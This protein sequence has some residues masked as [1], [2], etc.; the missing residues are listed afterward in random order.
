MPFREPFDDAGQQREAAT[1]GMWVF[2]VTELLLFGGLF[3]SYTVLRHFYPDAFRMGSMKTDY[4]KGTINT[5]VLLTSSLT[6]ALA[7]HAAQGRKRLAT[8]LLLLATFALGGVFMVIK[9][10]EYHSDALHHFVP[11]PAFD[12]SAFHGPQA[13]YVPL[14]F[15][16]YF[17]MTGLHAVH[18]T[19]ALGLVLLMT[20][21]ALT[22]RFVRGSSTPLELTGLFWHLVDV[23]WVFLYPLLYLIG[24]GHH[25]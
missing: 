4:W 11:G 13:H 3:L 16:A 21:L 14:F 17:L 23:V 1:L 8:V 7:V 5:A 22:G 15:T 2:L 6:M 20:A 19:I 9:F 25:G 24:G 10:S 12:Y 18:L